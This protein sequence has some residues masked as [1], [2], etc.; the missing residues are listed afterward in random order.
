MKDIIL[1][2][3]ANG[4]IFL[5]YVID[6]SG[7]KIQEKTYGN[8]K[9]MQ[10]RVIRMTKEVAKKIVR[11]ITD[12]I[13]CNTV[14]IDDWAEFWGFTKEEY[15]EFLDMAIKS[16][17]QPSWIPVTERLP[18]ANGRYVV[19]RELNAC[20]A[21]WNRVYIVNYS[22]LMGLKSERI[23]WNGNVGKSDFERFD[24][25]LAWQPLPQPYNAES[26]EDE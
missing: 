3:D 1:V 21:L 25:V 20:G 18:E 23:W 19:T 9:K 2:E 24:D 10:R 11:G 13:E 26:E 22:D 12:K 5:T 7:E 14:D 4:K 6:V 16:L 17:E 8:S 15:E